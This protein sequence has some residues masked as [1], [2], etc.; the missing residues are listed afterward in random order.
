MCVFSAFRSHSRRTT[1][2]HLIYLG[3]IAPPP[4]ANASPPSSC[5]GMCM[6]IFGMLLHGM[7]ANRPCR[8]GCRD[9]YLEKW[10]RA[11]CDGVAGIYCERKW[12]T[13]R[14]KSVWG[15]TR[16]KHK[17]DKDTQTCM[18]YVCGIFKCAMDWR[19]IDRADKV[20]ETYSR[21]RNRGICD[22]VAGI[23]G[24][25]GVEET[26]PKRAQTVDWCGDHI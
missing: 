20:A 4:I 17:Y 24:F 5:A 18:F 19:S 13:T 25:S 23:Y 1:R 26:P 15:W 6:C 22:K 11:I 21:L 12:R 14:L 3:N 16:K 7:G 8:Q 2:L 9:T 10:N